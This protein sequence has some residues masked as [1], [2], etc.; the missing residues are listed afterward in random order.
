MAVDYYLKIDGIKGESL[1]DKHKDEI[2]V[3][4]FSWGV[5][6]TGS[7]ATGGGSGAGKAQFQDLQISTNM[8][9]ASPLLFKACATGEHI[10]EATLS[11]RKAGDGKG[12]SDYLVIKMNDVL[13]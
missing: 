7:L 1:N 11:G 2:D 4:S 12:S 3:E 8:S 9:K 5:S 10:K 13:V 6:Q